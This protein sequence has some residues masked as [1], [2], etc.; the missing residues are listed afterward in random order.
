M[1]AILMGTWSLLSSS[2]SI[3][4]GARQMSKKIRDLL[5]PGAARELCDTDRRCLQLI[6]RR[7]EC[8]VP[9]LNL[10]ILWSKDKDSCVQPII[11]SAQEVLQNVLRFLDRAMDKNAAVAFDQQFS[12]A[13]ALFLEELQFACNSVNLAVS[14]AHHTLGPGEGRA[15]S[16]SSLLRA[17][18][19]IQEMSTRG[20]DMCVCTGKLFRSPPDQAWR[21][22]FPN[23]K[24]VFKVV[25][26]IEERTFLYIFSTRSCFKCKL[27]PLRFVRNPRRDR[28]A[29]TM[30]R[31]PERTRARHPH[32][33]PSRHG[34]RNRLRAEVPHHAQ[35]GG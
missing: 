11:R 34:Y 3:I 32:G 27:F 30:R 26:D 24:A 2:G 17:S 18:R 16:P 28:V 19:R 9:S 35:V 6:Q 8:L 12:D 4:T 21:V 33:N 7:V 23:D 20:G 22:A 10:L 31:F 29:C 25:R 15:L 14:I 13:L 5:Q 1:S